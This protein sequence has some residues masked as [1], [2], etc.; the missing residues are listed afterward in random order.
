MGEEWM[1][2][3]T[4]WASFER[5]WKYKEVSKLGPTNRPAAVGEW[6]GRGRP[7]TWR[8]VIGD[9]ARYESAFWKWWSGVQPD[10]RLEDGELVRKRLVGDW[11]PLRRPG[12][13]GVVSVLVGLFYWGLVVLEKGRGRAGWRSAVKDCHAAL[14]EL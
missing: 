1:E 5:Q 10:W 11:E 2:V 6:I 9:L 3:V 7:S 4:L 12:T 13:N 14:K 8:P